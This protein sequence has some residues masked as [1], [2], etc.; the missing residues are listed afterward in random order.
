LSLRI[1]RSQSMRCSSVSV[2]RSPTAAP[3]PDR[4]HRL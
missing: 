3:V 2:T 1:S 4:E